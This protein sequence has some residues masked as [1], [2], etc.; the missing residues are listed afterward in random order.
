MPPTLPEDPAPLAG[1]DSPSWWSNEQ[2]TRV[3]GLIG[4]RLERTGL[5][6]QGRIRVDGLSRPERHAISDLLGRPVTASRVVIDLAELDER[7]LLRSGTG[8]LDAAERVGHHALIDRGAQRAARRAKVDQT[9]ETAVTWLA[10]HPDLQWPW[11]PAWIDMMRR[12]G[13]L[14]RSQ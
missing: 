14:S 7:L 1:T 3:W 11:W 9:H 13:F 10:A 2:L 5:R 6:P 12:D 8:L 4:D